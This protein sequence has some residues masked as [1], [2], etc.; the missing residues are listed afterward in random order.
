MPL[1]VV[2]MER[3]RDRTVPGDLELVWFVHDV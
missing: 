2:E 1:S 3:K